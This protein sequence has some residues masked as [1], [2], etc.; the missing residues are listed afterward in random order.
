MNDRRGHRKLRLCSN[1]HFQPKPKRLPVSI[2]LQD[3]SALKVSVPPS[4][5]VSLPMSAYTDAPVESIETLHGRLK[6]SAVIPS[7]T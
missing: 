4:F 7:G 1:K 6:Q 2:P 5:K 3:V